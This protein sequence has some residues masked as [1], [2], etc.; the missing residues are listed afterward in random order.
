MNG[1]TIILDDNM[2]RSTLPSPSHDKQSDEPPDRRK[3]AEALHGI[4]SKLEQGIVLGQLH[5]RER[6]IEDDLMRR[7]STKRH[8]VRQALVDLEQ[9]GLVERIPH[10]GAQVRLYVPDEIQ[11]LYVLRDLLETHA[12]RLIPM[13]MSKPDLKDI[14]QIQKKHDQAVASGDLGRVFRANIEFHETLFSKAR[15]HYLT[16]AIRQFALRTHGMRFYCLADPGYLNQARDEHWLMID[17]IKKCDRP[18][19]VQLCSGHLLASRTCY[20]KALGM[21]GN[22]KVET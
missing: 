20:E 12:A 10:R 6:L 1:E 15:N 14:T 18:A 13:P 4:V 19:L 7:F 11:Q 5:P 8:V 22:M 16:E 9:M 21:I 3:D 17:A 2:K